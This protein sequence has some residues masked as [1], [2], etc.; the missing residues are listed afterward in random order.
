MGTSAQSLLDVPAI[1]KE[2]EYAGREEHDDSGRS[3]SIS[4]LDL[5]SHTVLPH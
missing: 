2:E 3:P 5:A 1:V 4:P